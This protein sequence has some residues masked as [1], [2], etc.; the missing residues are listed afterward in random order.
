MGGGAEF[1]IPLAFT[2]PPDNALKLANDL[3]RV[4]FNFERNFRIQ[5]EAAGDAST[6]ASI[7][8]GG[9]T[10]AQVQHS[11]QSSLAGLHDAEVSAG[12]QLDLVDFAREFQELDDAGVATKCLEAISVAFQGKI[13]DTRHL[14]WSAGAQAGFDPDLCFFG[15]STDLAFQHQFPVRGANVT[16]VTSGVVGIRFGPG[17]R[18]YEYVAQRV[19][20]PAIEQFLIRTLPR[21]VEEGALIGVLRAMGIWAFAIQSGYDIMQLSQWICRS[22]YQRGVQR[23]QAY[24]YASAYIR[25]VY[26]DRYYRVVPDSIE[27]GAIEQARRDARHLG[28]VLLRRRLEERFNE[29]RHFHINRTQHFMTTDSG[30][31]PL[32][33]RFGEALDSGAPILG[34]Y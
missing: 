10:G 26:M 15:I 22:A 9:A 20:V 14:T 13:V 30:L 4:K 34:R 27:R 12:A 1:S 25:T 29:G 18:A 5:I 31:E 28:Y 11:L 8:F 23:G 19:G 33:N 7:T 17:L 16:A 6:S 3:V 21:L 32:I 24:K 2:I